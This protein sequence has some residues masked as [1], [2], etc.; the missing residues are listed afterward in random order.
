MRI[1]DLENLE[2]DKNL[3]WIES[4]YVYSCIDIL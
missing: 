4:L 3:I 2:L 1:E